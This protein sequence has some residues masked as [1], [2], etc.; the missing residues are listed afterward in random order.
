MRSFSLF[1]ILRFCLVPFS[2][3][4]E[5]VYRMRRFCYRYGVFDQKRFQVP[6]IS[7]GNLTFGGT[8]KTP[9]ILF[10]GKSFASQGKRSLILTRGYKSVLENSSAL[11]K[12]RPFLGNSPYEYGDESLMLA[13]NLPGTSI[14]IGKRRAENLDF[15]LRQERPDVVLMDDGHQHLNLDRDLNIVLFDALMPLSRYRT[16]PL[17]YMREGFSALE[18]SDIVGMTRADQA[19]ESKVEEL[20]GLLS[21]YLPPNVPFFEMGLRPSC[22]RGMGLQRISLSKLNSQKTIC[23]AGIAS[24][25]SFFLTVASLGAD[26]IQKHSFPDHYQYGAQDLL[27]ISQE[28]E[29]EGAMIVM[30]EK[31]MNKVRKV[32]GDGRIFFL[33]IETY[34][35][36]GEDLFKERVERALSRS[37]E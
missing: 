8:G 32:S 9:L 35:L 15:Y 16:P 34:F 13:K 12:G 26:I 22:L 30:T 5:G 37:R 29:K 28:A 23:V 11:L 24:P 7:V 27:E 1:K 6:I 25:Q 4:W 18:D 21:S 36:K 10:L 33:E 19:G 17:G 3:A 31:D 14:V 2:A 20:K